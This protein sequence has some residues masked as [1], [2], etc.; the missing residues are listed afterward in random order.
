MRTA[1]LA[2]AVMAVALGGLAR[3]QSAADLPRLLTD[4]ASDDENVRAAATNTLVGV[5]V[6][7][8]EPLFGLLPA[9]QPVVNAAVAQALW[10]I[11]T[12]AADQAAEREP[13]RELLQ[14]RLAAE[15]PA[16]VRGLAARL[17][18]GG[19]GTEAL[20]DLLP[21]LS[22]PDVTAAV[23]DAT[24]RIT[25]PEVTRALLA[26]YPQA[27]AAGRAGIVAVIGARRD[28]AALPLVL[29]AAGSDD[30]ALRMEALTALG[31]LGNLEG[32]P[33]VE[34]ALTA[35]PG[36]LRDA[37][38][39]SYLSLA[40]V[41]LRGGEAPRALAMCVRVLDLPQPGEAAVV[42]ALTGA[43][44]TRQVA[45]LEHLTPY[46]R[47]PSGAVQR[48]ASAAVQC[49]PGPEAT[50]ALVAAL[51][52]ADAA[53][54]P[55]ILSALSARADP[56]TVPA[57]VAAAASQDEGVRVAALAALGHIG[58]PA[59]IPTLEAAIEA[60]TD[61][62][63]GAAMSAYLGVAGKV[64][65]QGDRGRAAAI[66]VRV[67]QGSAR[68]R[69]QVAAV[70]GLGRTGVR[71]A[72]GPLEAVL[73]A[74]AG[75]LRDEAVGALVA[76]AGATAEQQRDE[77]VRLYRRCLGLLPA[78]EAAADVARKLTALG[79]PTDV[80]WVQGF[81]THWWLCGPFPSP[82]KSGFDRAFPPEEGRVDL[83]ARYQFEGQ[84]FSWRK[85][86][87][88][89]EAGTT[90]ILPLFTPNEN[91]ASYAYAEVTSPQAQDVLLKVGTDDGVVVWVNEAQVH[92]NNASRG[93]IVDQDVVPARLE[94]GA[95]RILVK[96]LQGGGLAG[97]CLRL[98]DR[99]GRPLRLEQKTE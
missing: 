29:E 46:M 83:A 3:A 97:Y 95:N 6:P 34:A 48:A 56:S 21:M 77:A 13:V 94:A 80:A 7:A 35:E 66:Y 55:A 31:A 14:A 58:D 30:A 10:W 89:N 45:A 78:G 84:E 70:R 16:A 18:A 75:P 99:D 27:D 23:R 20:A 40:G 47:D 87:E 36:P 2:L 90:D 63:R 8:I 91:I 85:Y 53:L 86:H 57:V 25:G 28:A 96:V 60:G 98:T 73:D 68:G 22:D 42:E 5:G 50:A 33:P 19:Y 62:V 64:L 51:R 11:V 67:L 15:H 12:A 69:E 88:G 59:A 24:E 79:V 82:N 92:A 61:R 76:V 32:I 81:V 37:A 9:E 44:R 52:E 43:G 74:G 39:A 49:V 26:A 1:A 65:A 71:E 17:L 38:I 72:V 41:V 4:L 54:A 93:L